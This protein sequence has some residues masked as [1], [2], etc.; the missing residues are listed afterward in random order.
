MSRLRNNLNTTT[1]FGEK[2]KKKAE[3]WK[4]RAE[5]KRIPDKQT[6]REKKDFYFK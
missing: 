4:M 1:L 5:N 2:R 3:S 6:N